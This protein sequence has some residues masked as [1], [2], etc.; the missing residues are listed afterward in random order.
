MSHA[1]LDAGADDLVH[2]VLIVDEVLE[3]G[4]LGWGRGKPVLRFVHG[5]F[6]IDF[7]L[8]VLAIAKF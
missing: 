5:G 3:R 2:R 1:V 6:D 4:E 7:H 8:D